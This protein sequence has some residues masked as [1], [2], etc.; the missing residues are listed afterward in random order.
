VDN[1]ADQTEIS[2]T[3]HNK[4]I[5]TLKNQSRKFTKQ[6]AATKITTKNTISN[7]KTCKDEKV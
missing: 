7:T 3:T 5:Q 4:E 6:T 2:V 1:I